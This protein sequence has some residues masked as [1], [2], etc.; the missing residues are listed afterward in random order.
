MESSRTKMKVQIG[1]FRVI[2]V[3]SNAIRIALGQGVNCWIH[4]NFEH[5]TH[6]GDMIPLFAEIP[7]A[8]TGPTSI[9]RT[10]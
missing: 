3:Q 1:E 9:E 10:S 8:L 6:P 2:D 7:Y 5:N 4:M